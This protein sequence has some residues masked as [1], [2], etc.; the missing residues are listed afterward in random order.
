[1]TNN[2]EFSAEA[3][4]LIKHAVF[5]D[6]R[7]MATIA[8]AAYDKW[9]REAIDVMC[10]AFYAFG[11]ADG[12]EY[13]RAAGY[14]G[15]EDEIDVKVVMTEI[16]GKVFKYLSIAG[17]TREGTTLTPNEYC[18]NILRCPI[19]AAWQ[20]VWDKP[21]FM[22]E[23]AKNYDEGFMHSVNPKLSWENYPGKNGETG[24][25]HA[26]PCEKLRLVLKR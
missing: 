4:A 23:L 21:W 18:C 22:C 13:K 7:W 24:L 17:I 16:Y 26:C 8:K 1:M 6:G 5:M 14:E 12:K 3:L 19:L 10:K 9:G 15:R 20:S 11:E 2:S 25:A